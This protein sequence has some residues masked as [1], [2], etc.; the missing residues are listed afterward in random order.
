M[1]GAPT[2]FGEPTR[3]CVGCRQ[4]RVTAEL[5]RFALDD[6]GALRVDYRGVAPGRGAWMCPDPRC[7]QQAL[8]RNA[9]FRSFRRR[10]SY[11]TAS[12]PG[13]V[14]QALVN[15]VEGAF[16]SARRAGSV[17]MRADSESTIGAQRAEGDSLQENST[18][19][20]TAL[21]ALSVSWG[22]PRKTWV[23]SNTVWFERVARAITQLRTWESQLASLSESTTKRGRRKRGS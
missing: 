10:V 14:S 5:L 2:R 9:F 19:N 6:S 18:A 3:T 20:N 8:K 7:L 13:E 11:D 23:I 12:L 21:A 15:R 16:R 22:D 1:P 17:T 4:T